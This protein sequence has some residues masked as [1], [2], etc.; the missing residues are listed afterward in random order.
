MLGRPITAVAAV[1]ALGLAPATA[2]ATPRDMAATHAYIQ[3]NFALASASEARIGSTQ[4]SIE[5][6]TRQF[7]HECRNVGAGSPQDEEAQKLSYEAVGAV[8]AV[9]YGANA[10]P[11]RAFARAVR[12]LR[13]SNAKLTRIAQG[14]AQSLRELAALAMPDLCGD[15]RAWKASGFQT[16]PATTLRFDEH[17][18]SIEG[19][20]IPPRLLAPYEQPTDRGTLARTTRMEA[21]LEHLEFETGIEDWLSLLDT[22]GL[23]Q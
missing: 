23:K 8:W 3:A 6:R 12:P 5:R 18:E 1:L 20:S 10:G 21:D 22:L 2:S 9:S 7:G 16:V 19:H 13:W 14:Y 17:V 11:I 4:T 15:T